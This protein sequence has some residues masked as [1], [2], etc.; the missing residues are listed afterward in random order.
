M[1][2]YPNEASNVLLD[3]P[4]I[5]VNENRIRPEGTCGFIWLIWLHQTHHDVCSREHACPLPLL[6]VTALAGSPPFS[7]PVP[8]TMKPLR[9][10]YR[11]GHTQTDSPESCLCH[12]LHPDTFTAVPML[13]TGQAEPFKLVNPFYTHQ[14][15]VRHKTTS[16]Q[17]Q[18]VRFERG[19]GMA[20]DI[21]LTGFH[22]FSRMP[23]AE[24]LPARRNSLYS[25]FTS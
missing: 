5:N 2:R 23:S 13:R 19:T 17:A 12:A 25:A 3:L 6:E 8:R 21:L 18:V 11:G 16:N 14:M 10:V 20:V 7:R 4:T 15:R 1:H 22:D 24:S 9:L